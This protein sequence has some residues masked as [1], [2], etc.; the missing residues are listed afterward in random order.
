MDRFAKIG[1]GAGQTFD[2]SKLSPETKKAIE[3][4]MADAWAEFQGL[5][6]RVNKGEVSSGDVFGTREFLKNNYLN[7]MGAAVLGIYGNTKEEAIYP[8]YYVD[9][10]K[11]K[12][13]GS[14]RYTLR[15]AKGQLPPV[16]SFWSLTM[17]DQ[18]ASLLVHNPINRYL[19]N[20]TML[21]EFQMDDDGGL[22]LYIQ[23][24]SPGKDRE[25]N[26]LPA[27]KG[28]FSVIMRLYWPKAEAVEGQ[29]KQPPLTR[30]K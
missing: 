17:Y 15:F 12:L 19:L 28:P 25:A 20:S 13:D 24:E 14:H 8:A 26:W 3:E 4:G 11:Q 5:V 22:T 7:R 1:I 16:N 30:V 21:S 29:W 6:G 10:D 9:G 27:P 18:P 23:N 2:P